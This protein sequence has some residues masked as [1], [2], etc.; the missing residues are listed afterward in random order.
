VQT[1][2]VDYTIYRKVVSQLL[3]GEENL[4][5]LPS[6]TMD[7]R[8]A[9]GHP[10]VSMAKVSQLIAK[11]PSLSAILLKYA[12][13]ALFHLEKPPQTL[14]DV[15]RILGMSQLERVTMVHSINSLFAVHSPQHKRLFVE[16]WNRIALKASIGMH[17][18]KTLH[19]INP[20][21]A[22]LASL[23]SEIGTLAVLSAFKKHDQIPSLEIYIDLCREYAKSLGVIML[24]RW[25]VD[26]EYIQVIRKTGDWTD[27]LDRPFNLN[28]LVNLSLYHSVKMKNKTP[29]LPPI[30]ELSA[31]QKLTSPQNALTVNG[32][33][34][35]VANQVQEIK[36]IA[37]TLFS[38]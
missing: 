30:Q 33:L 28:D 25:H 27:G 23:L 13:S 20:D 29:G 4:P 7:I 31:Y 17:L 5:S 1:A 18:A 16:A 32:S 6:I 24:K 9:I 26:E 19:K 35:I 3:Q 2:H 11:D 22:L 34:L 21:H 10:N 14:L 15:V 12:S 36:N 37:R 8:R 38:H